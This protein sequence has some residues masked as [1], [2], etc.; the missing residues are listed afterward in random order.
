VE[1]H[2]QEIYGMS[3]AEV[4]EGFQKCMP[5]G[6]V[7]PDLGPIPPLETSLKTSAAA[8]LAINMLGLSL[9]LGVLLF[10]LS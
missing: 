9:A 6:A 8:G 2:V 1:D 10:S 7:V 3:S 4:V 5:P